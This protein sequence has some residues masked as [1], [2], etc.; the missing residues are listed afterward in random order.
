MAVQKFMKVALTVPYGAHA[1]TPVQASAHGVTFKAYV[2][3]NLSAGQIFYVKIP[4]PQRGSV[5]NKTLDIKTHES[6]TAIFD[7]LPGIS[8]GSHKY[9]KDVKTCGDWC[10]PTRACCPTVTY[11]AGQ[12]EKGNPTAIKYKYGCVCCPCL[13]SYSTY[14][15]EG[16]VGTFDRASCCDQNKCYVFCPCCYTGEY[17]IAKFGDTQGQTKF[18]MRGEIKCCQHLCVCLVALCMP[19][20]RCC[21]FCCSDKQYVEYEQNIYGPDLDN[22][23]PVAKITYVERMLCPCVPDERVHMAIEGPGLTEDDIVL[24]S[25]FPMLASGFNRAEFALSGI[26]GPQPSGIGSIDEAH[27][28]H[29]TWHDQAGALDLTEKLRMMK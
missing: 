27:K 2:P 5:N 7:M 23:T 21:R 14:F 15:N 24:L 9:I 3:A 8:I 12:D 11:S 29:G 20:A 19:C 26:F 1:G 17:M 22:K 6:P 25:T 13:S 18:T 16:L 4:I 10:N 28:I